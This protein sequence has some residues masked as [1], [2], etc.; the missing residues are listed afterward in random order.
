MKKLLFKSL[1]FLMVGLL[2]M[3]QLALPAKAVTEFIAPYSIVVNNDSSSTTIDGVE[4]VGAKYSIR[5]TQGAYDAE[6]GT[7]GDVDPAYATEQ[8]VQI[9]PGETSVTWAD[10][11]EGTYEIKEV[12]PATGYFPFGHADVAYEQEEGNGITRTNDGWIVQFPQTVDGEHVEGPEVVELNPKTTPIRGNAE[13]QKSLDAILSE[14]GVFGPGAEIKLQRKNAAGEYVDYVAD[15]LTGDAINNL[16]VSGEAD[17]KILVENLPAGEYR[18]VE[19][20]PPTGYQLSI[21]TPEFLI[22]ADNHATNQTSELV[23]YKTPQLDK[24]IVEGTNVERL[25][26]YDVRSVHNYAEVE[27]EVSE[28]WIYKADVLDNR[29]FSYRITVPVP[30]GIELYKDFH[31][32]DNVPFAGLATDFEVIN[33]DADLVPEVTIAGQ[34]VKV[35]YTS[36]VES[37]KGR[38]SVSFDIKVTFATS[39]ELEAILGDTKLNTAVLHYTDAAGNPGT[40]EDDELI[41]FP[42]GQVN[43]TKHDENGELLDGASFKLERLEPDNSWSEVVASFDAVDGQWTSEDLLPGSYRITE[44]K[45]PSG[46]RLLDQASV[47]EITPY[48]IE[49]VEANVTINNFPIEDEYPATGTTG[50]LLWKL[51]GGAAILSGLGLI[52]KNKKD[53]RKSEE[54]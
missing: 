5:M 52:A 38:E 9:Q 50:A 43:L 17:G 51:G 34:D 54:E 2:A 23:N 3:T 25:P 12:S 14:G 31:V 45:A 24:I 39:E 29:S 20:T 15:F 37:L 16:Y 53:K 21:E 11:P 40:T 46:Y 27:G 7:F 47:F 35:D 6:S 19:V 22:H 48:G 4:R 33:N 10:L 36:I 28:Q 18:W 49:D 32:T 1:T 13:L 44:I 42:K 26:L 30:S 41:Y 8:E